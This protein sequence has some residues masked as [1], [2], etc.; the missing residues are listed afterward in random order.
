LLGLLADADLKPSP[1][2]PPMTAALHRELARLRPDLPGQLE[3]EVFA[4]GLLVFSSLCGLVS[5]E[6]FG[7]FTNTVTQF[8]GH[9]DHQLA[10]LGAVLGLPEPA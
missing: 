3:P 2:D 7:Q 1:D 9:L 10:R 6:L 4:R 5:L 8:P